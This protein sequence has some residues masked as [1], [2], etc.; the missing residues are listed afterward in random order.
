VRAID[1]VNENALID[2][3]AAPA[4]TCEIAFQRVPKARSFRRFRGAWVLRSRLLPRSLP[5]VN[6]SCRWRQVHDPGRSRMGCR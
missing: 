4:Q 3:D 1:E 2:G 5:D 6:L